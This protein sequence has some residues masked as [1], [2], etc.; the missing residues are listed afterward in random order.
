MLTYRWKCRG[1]KNSPVSSPFVIFHVDLWMPGHYTDINGY[2]TLMNV[3]YDMRQF[4][5]VD[6]VSDETQALNLN[7]GILAKRNYKGFTLNIY[8][9]S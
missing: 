6:L 3:I 2:M 8:I 5:V 7:F 4:A 1:P 9:I